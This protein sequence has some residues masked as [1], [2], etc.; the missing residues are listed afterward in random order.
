MPVLE[1]FSEVADPV[2]YR[3]I[4]DDW[5]IGVSDVVDS[6]AAIEAGHYKAVNLAG[7]ATISAISNALPG[8]PTLFAFGGDGAHFALSPHQALV[9][10]EALSSVAGWAQRDLGLQLRVG[11]TS[12]EEVRSAGLDVRV[13]FWQASDHV[14]YAMFTGGGLEWSET[15]LKSG[16]IGLPA[17]DE[18]SQPDLSGLSCQWAPIQARQGAILS[19]IVKRASNTSQTAFAE[20]ATRVI[21]ALETGTSLNPV[22]PEGPKVRWPSHAIALQSRIANTG[23]PGWWRRTSVLVTSAFYWAVFKLG[24]RIGRFDPEQYRREIA[25]NTD[26]RKF[27]DGLMMTVDCSNDTADRLRELLDEATGRGIIPYGLHLQDEALMTCVVPSALT[28]NH[29]HFVDGSGGGYTSAA[30]NLRG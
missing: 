18:N 27:D 12:V 2:R 22:P 29:M 16:A 1:H 25:T 30:R 8:D 10:A 23:R 13:A 21:E 26:F 17:A 20:T 15:Q 9:A 28:S 24:S 4:P 11:I 3:P 14:R 7:A 5:L 19:L 6:T